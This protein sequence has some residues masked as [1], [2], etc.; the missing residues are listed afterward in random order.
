MLI[1]A[2]AIVIGCLA[3][4]LIPSSW[5]VLQNVGEWVFQRFHTNQET[6]VLLG[7][8]I[9]LPVFS[10]A[11]L[12]GILAL[13]RTFRSA[14]GFTYFISDLHFQDGR[15][16]VRYS[17]SHGFGSL[18]L[19]FGQG[20]VG[21]EGFA[22]EIL[23]T[24]G[25]KFGQWAKLSN[26]QV[27]TLSACGAAA[28]LAA[29]LGQPTAAFLFVVEL[30]YGWGTFS[31]AIGP[32]AVAAFVAQSVSQSLTSPNGIYHS[33]F[34]PDAGLSL[35][36]RAESF[37]LTPLTAVFCAVVLSLVAG[38]VASFSIYIHRKTDRELHGLFETRRA[39]DVSSAAFLVRVGI[40]A[41]LTAF[42]I[43]LFPQSLG[44]GVTLLHESL[45]QGY[46]LSVAVIAL[47]LRILMGA[48]TYSVI[49]SIGL[50][51][52][53]L[54]AGGILGAAVALGSHG[55]IAVNQ[56]T[57]ALLCMGAYFSASFGTPVAATALVFGFA[58]GFMTDSAL[59]LFT[60]LFTN[61]AAHFICGY[62]QSDRMASMGLYRHG[63]RFRAGMCFNTLSGI[64][65]RD[66]M[67]TYASPIPS[68]SSIGDAYKRLMESK[69]PV[70]PVVK[71]GK[72][73]GMVSLSDFYGLDAWRKLGEE[74]Q[75][76]NLVGVEEMLKPARV[77]LLPEM[78]LETALQN[79]SDEECVPVVEADL[80]YVGLLVKSD[81]VNLYNKEVVKKAFRRN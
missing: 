49:G 65:V 9:F 59:F 51:F 47:L 23:S 30:L 62:F 38:L 17:F 58:T 41:G 36:F 54:I 64:Q 67:I 43:Y 7:Y 1:W 8:A 63:I 15:R 21:V 56:T 13:F 24:L 48:L 4:I 71:E 35:A 19:L 60:A 79:M 80:S 69:F 39:T 20:V 76:H 74:S 18:L 81:L 32:Y 5:W 45:S 77:S 61:F 31:F 52:P 78:N 42:A 27:R 33:L 40:W 3:G 75:V 37:Q 50:V 73:Q 2:L 57:V 29:L 26:N 34:A 72:M 55:F 28:S 25:S 44:S 10:G 16:K 6:H 66:A 46:L 22:I 12:Y 14:D 70:L 11:L 53:T 68:E